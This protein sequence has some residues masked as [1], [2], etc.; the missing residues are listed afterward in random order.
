[1]KIL[2]VVGNGM[3]ISLF[4][5]AKEDYEILSAPL[6]FQCKHERDKQ[7][8][9]TFPDLKNLISHKSEVNQP[10]FGDFRSMLDIILQARNLSNGEKI[11][12]QMR[13][14]LTYYYS[15]VDLCIRDS[16]IS[17]WPW[18]IWLS[19]YKRYLKYAVSFNYDIF[20]ERGMGL[21]DITYTNY[22]RRSQ[23]V[24]MLYDPK[25]LDGVPLSKPHGSINFSF[26]E[27]VL[28][29]KNASFSDLGRVVVKH[30]DGFHRIIPRSRLLD[31]RFGHDIV[32]PTQPSDIEN[33][34][35]VS[36]GFEHLR[37]CAEDF[38]HCIVLGISY[39]DCD[40]PELYRIF[41]LLAPSVQFIN[42]NKGP[43][44]EAVARRLNDKF[45]SVRS[46]LDGSPPNL[47]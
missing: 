29:R 19:K 9:E 41:D 18:H 30:C 28:S 31:L 44:P 11:L 1:M 8:I 21:R 4:Q 3:S 43:L 42:V 34:A 15:I 22:D 2:F 14:Y 20:F 26:S 38:T 23:D 25:P 40:R 5:H 39:W 45:E 47:D 24:S 46:I 16:V 17:T 32:L 6:R 7:L 35:W 27:G 36:R 10:D 12:F 37:A 33:L 13:A